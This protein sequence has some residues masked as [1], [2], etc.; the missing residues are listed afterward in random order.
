MITYKERLGIE[1][2]IGNIIEKKIES[3]KIDNQDKLLIF[4]EY[5][6]MI[7]EELTDEY[8]EKLDSDK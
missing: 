6:E 4:T 7:I 3:G 5:I 8:I 1:I 2:F